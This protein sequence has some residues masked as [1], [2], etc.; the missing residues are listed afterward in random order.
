MQHAK[1]E[2]NYLRYVNFP[3]LVPTIKFRCQ[4][5]TWSTNQAMI[6]LQP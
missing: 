5:T 3:A 2:R 6:Y 1:D 4:L